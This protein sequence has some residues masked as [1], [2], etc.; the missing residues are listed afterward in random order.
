MGR[1]NKKHRDKSRGVKPQRSR[2]SRHNDKRRSH[3]P[4]A[5]ER[6]DAANRRTISIETGPFTIELSPLE[7][8]LFRRTAT[9][10]DRELGRLSAAIWIDYEMVLKIDHHKIEN[11][12]TKSIVML[13]KMGAG[14]PVPFHTTR[15]LSPD[16]ARNQDRLWEI[17]YSRLPVTGEKVCTDLQ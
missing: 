13:W 12:K 5:A 15:L 4:T 9:K 11:A 16:E 3:V 17:A 14:I 6:N 10:A 2:Q 7:A 1:F 8:S